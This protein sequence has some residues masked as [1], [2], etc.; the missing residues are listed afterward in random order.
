[1]SR[2]RRLFQRQKSKEVKTVLVC[3]DLLLDTNI[4][5]GDAAPHIL[6]FQNDVTKRIK[7]YLYFLL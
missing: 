6:H 5:V 3:P 4:M 7:F 2:A 1:M